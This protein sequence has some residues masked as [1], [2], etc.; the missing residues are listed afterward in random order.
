VAVSFNGGGN[1]STRRKP[2]TCRGGWMGESD[3]LKIRCFM[4]VYFNLISQQTWQYSNNDKLS[5]KFKELKGCFF[6]K[7]NCTSPLSKFKYILVG[8]CAMCIYL[9]PENNKLL[10]NYEKKVMIV[11]SSNA[12]KSDRKV[13]SGGMYM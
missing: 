4:S 7:N 2:P 12:I 8:T 10:F 11:Y 9:C 5:M 13:K 6:K 1:R 3:T